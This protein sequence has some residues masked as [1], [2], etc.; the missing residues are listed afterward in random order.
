MPLSTNVNVKISGSIVFFFED[1]DDITRLL[2]VL[3]EG[4]AARRIFNDDV[5]DLA[6]NLRELLENHAK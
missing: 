1:L 4:L 2:G 3:D 5:A 6:D